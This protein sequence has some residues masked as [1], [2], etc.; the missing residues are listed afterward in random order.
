MDRQPST[1]PRAGMSETW[2]WVP[3]VAKDLPSAF[4]SPSYEVRSVLPVSQ[5]SSPSTGH[6][7]SWVLNIYTISEQYPFLFTTSHWERD[8]EEVGYPKIPQ[9]EQVPHHYEAC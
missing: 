5:E 9:Q 8:Q 4:L 1:L 7:E 2:P 3:R 6:F